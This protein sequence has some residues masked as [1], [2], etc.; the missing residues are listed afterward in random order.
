MSQGFTL[1]PTA[2]S[3]KGSTGAIFPS[4]VDPNSMSPPMFG[5]SRTFTR[6]TKSGSRLGRRSTRPEQRS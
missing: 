4:L 3:N 5:M 1:P 6:T 2:P